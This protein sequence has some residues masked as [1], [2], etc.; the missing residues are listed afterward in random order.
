MIK[1]LLLI[2]VIPFT[3]LAFSWYYGM[4]TP[5]NIVTA[6]RDI[7]NGKVRFI[8]FGLPLESPQQYEID[9]LSSK[10]GIVDTTI[11]CIVTEAEIRG[12]KWYNKEI[13]RHLEVRNGKG[14]MQRFQMELDSILNV[15]K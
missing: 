14:W 2:F 3:I 6:K 13:E 9:A 8:T 5:Y 7:R 1:R 10:Y 12:I 11:G 15:N 4:F